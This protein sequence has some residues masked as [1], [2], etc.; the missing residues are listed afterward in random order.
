MDA[1]TKWLLGA[2]ALAVVGYFGLIYGGCVL[3]PRCHLR[4]CPNRR[5]TCGVI[6]D[7][8]DVPRAR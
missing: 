4:S 7:R 8:D 5:Y 6:Y 1:L 3:D 2:T